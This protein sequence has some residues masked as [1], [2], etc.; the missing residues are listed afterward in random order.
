[1]GKMVAYRG[2][3]SW[4]CSMHQQQKQEQEQKG[5]EK[6]ETSGLWQ[7]VESWFVNRLLSY[8]ILFWFPDLKIRK[9]LSVICNCRQLG[10]PSV[11][12]PK[13]GS[14]E[15]EEALCWKLIDRT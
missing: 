3:M 7:S 5:A 15:Y 4:M 14:R 11:W 13:P 10:W 6:E 8:V 9:S 12:S 2:V 1:M